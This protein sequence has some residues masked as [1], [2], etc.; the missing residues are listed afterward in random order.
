MKNKKLKVV[1][2]CYFTNQF[3][4]D[5]IR[6]LKRINEFGPWISSLIP[7]FEN[8]DTV[9]LHVVSQHRWIR[10]YKSIQSKGV[11]YHFF[12]A[13]IPVIGRHW[14]GFFRFD[15]WSDFLVTKMY[16]SRII[17]KINPDIIHLHG[18]ENEFSV[19]IIKFHN[20]Y[21]VFITI[22][23]FFFKSPS[24]KSI[25][26]KKSQNELQIIKMF[27]HFGYRTNTMGEEI[28]A[29]NKNAILHWHMYP[30]QTKLP[31]E[32]NKKYDLV[33]FARVSK[34]KGIGDLL[35]AVSIVK[36]VK[37]DIS[38]CVIGGG[39]LGIWKV[40]AKELDL[41]GNVHW[42]GFLPTQMDVY[43]MASSARICVLPTYHDII[44]GTII[45]SL[46]MKLPVV[47]YDVG[48]IHEINAYEKLIFL[49]EKFNING[50]A[51]SILL[52]L[53]DDKLRKETAEKGYVRAMEMFNA[54]NDKIKSD[55]LRAYNEVIED[56]N[57]IKL[58]N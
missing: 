12:N 23:G 34:D 17:K 13:G 4:Q 39:K 7:L 31:V 47:S 21:P 29:I 45:E 56:F 9:E 58:K 1:W 43:N 32:E 52:L 53:D 38:L 26:Y 37:P 16:F 5:K 6:S 33:F 3:V 46:F 51:E 48:S 11:T 55:L 49:V 35:Q 28:K 44:P 15:V 50:L 30:F 22:Q 19:A 18:A 8:D 25:T 42:A 14:P 40:K 10:G 20:K 24:K 41:S 36:K 27:N 2:F 57:N 54:G